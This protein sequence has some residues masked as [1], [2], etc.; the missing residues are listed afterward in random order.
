LK[1]R[2]Q[3][4]KH[5]S[6]S[7]TSAVTG[8]LPPTASRSSSASSREIVARAVDSQRVLAPGDEEDQTD[9]AVLDDV[10]HAVE[11]V[12]AEP[13]GDDQVVLVEHLHEAGGVT[14]GRDVAAAVGPAVPITRKGAWVMN[15]RQCS[16]MTG[17]SLATARSPG[18]P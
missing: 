6:T 4:R 5:C 3:C 7:T 16:S 13:V 10:A 14:L 1:A 15:S 2:A 9:V 8:R 12:V 11:A 18:C 17:C